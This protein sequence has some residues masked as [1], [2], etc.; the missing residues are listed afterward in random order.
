MGHGNI[1][2]GADAQLLSRGNSSLDYEAY[3]STKKNESTTWLIEN[4]ID[5]LFSTVLETPL[6]RSYKSHNNR[7]CIPNY[8]AELK[9]LTAARLIH[10]FKPQHRDGQHL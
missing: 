7:N 3:R 4:D 10:V 9:L 6:P 1:Q 8:N 5:N 2:N